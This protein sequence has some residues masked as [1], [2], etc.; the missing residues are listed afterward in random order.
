[1]KKKIYLQPAIEITGILP[2]RLMAGTEG[3]A[4]DGNPPT[5]VEQEKAV[6]EDDK[7]QSSGLWDEGYGGFLDLD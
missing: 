1:M 3:W 2:I 5:A 7:L 6:S 4:K